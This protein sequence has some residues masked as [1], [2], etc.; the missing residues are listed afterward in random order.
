VTGAE[1]A[2]T[3]ASVVHRPAVLRVPGFAPAVLLGRRGADEF[4]LAGQRMSA[5]RATELGYSFRHPELRTGL[6]HVLART[7]DG[8]TEV[9]EH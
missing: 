3:L 6:E 9:E 8:P 5:A 4:A 2:R 1:Y 7:T